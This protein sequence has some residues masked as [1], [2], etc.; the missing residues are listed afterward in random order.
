MIIVNES[1]V[2]VF[3]SDELKSALQNDNG[4]DYIYFGS[5]ITITSGIAISS[6]KSEVT[7]DGLYNGVMY[8]YTDQKKLGTSDGIYVT[9][10][11]TSKVTFK[12]MTVTG[13][14]YY[15]IVYVPESTGYSNTT[16]EYS[17]VTYT[18]PQMSYNPSGTTRFLNCY[19]T[20]KENYAAGNEVAECNK[21]EVG[22]FTT[23]IHKST[24]NSSF[25]FRN[26]TPTFTILR[27]AK[28]YFTSSSREL[29]YGPT[30]LKL[31]ISKGSSFYVYAN[32]GLAYG[33]NGTGETEIQENAVFSISK[34]GY[35]GGYAT[36][37]SYGTITMG[38][39]SELSVIN[40]YTNITSSNYNISLMGTQSG[41]IFNNP[42]KV[43]LYNSVA[44]VINV[45]NTAS[46]N[47]T[48]SR[49]NLFDKSIT[50]TD[51]IS[52][53]TLP[54]YSWYKSSELSNVVGTFTNSKTSITSNNYTEE[55]LKT[56]PGLDNFVIGNKKILSIG[57]FS[58]VVD[59]LTDKDTTMKGKT[60]S[61]A[62]VLVEY[63]DVSVV[64]QANE[65]GEFTYSYDS[66][67]PVGTIITLT[68]KTYN[69]VIYYTKEIQIVYS[70]ELVIDSATK[71]FQ[72]EVYAISQNPVLCP[73]LST[74]NITVIDSRVNSSEWK[75]YATINH[76]MESVSGEKLKNSLVFV[77]D[78]GNMTVLSDTPTLVY[79]GKNN[80]G[81]TLTTVVEWEEQKGILLQLIDPL[82]N[83]ENYDAEITWTIEE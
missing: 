1:T 18:G 6:S 80:G 15:G 74:L 26:T 49:I 24:A 52:K 65:E 13:Y 67:L 61:D 77:D 7:I 19:I 41:L 40:N 11:L 54:T 44:N 17:N 76:D 34:T 29:F 56:L 73:R 81:E 4:Y 68:C 45:Q 79:T 75:L 78:T 25:W 62:S 83:N 60:E 31:T 42:A 9:S 27:D 50:L 22:G 66:A 70:G 2:V 8:E 12:N 14:N 69:D 30:N 35:N 64:L 71:H 38:K 63:E 48:Y 10:P 5:N 21:I 82:M 58:F 3:S 53:D 23:I 37:Y 36:W 39:G 57:T 28:V 46:F 51:N 32:N 43:V 16:I 20:V 72:F 33:T 47:F 55:E 59:P